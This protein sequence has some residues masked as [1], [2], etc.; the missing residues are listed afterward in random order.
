MKTKTEQIDL[1]IENLEH[2][3]LF[4]AM[5]FGSKD[6]VISAQSYLNGVQ[7]AVFSLLELDKYSYSTVRGEVVTKRGHLYSAQG[8]SKELKAEGFTDEQIVQ[9]LLDIEIELWKIYRDSV[10]KN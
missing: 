9:K 3:K 4:P 6:D 5:Y 2:T 1:I 10:E 7:Q 8:V